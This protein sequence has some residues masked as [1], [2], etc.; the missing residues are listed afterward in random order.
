M[1]K[2]DSSL[3]NR[4]L[5]RFL[6]KMMKGYRRNWHEYYSDTAPDAR[7]SVKR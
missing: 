7:I 2:G 4:P 6:Q 5:L 3:M 1:L